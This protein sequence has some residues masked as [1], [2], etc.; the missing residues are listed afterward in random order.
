MKNKYVGISK[1][2]LNRR[3]MKKIIG[4]IWFFFIIVSVSADV[5]IDNNVLDYFFKGNEYYAKGNYEEAIKYL[6]KAIEIEKD[7]AEAYYKI[8]LALMDC[9]KEEEAILYLKKAIEIDPENGL[10]YYLMGYANMK[11]NEENAIQC[12]NVSIDIFKNALASDKK[13]KLNNFYKEEIAI[14]F[15]KMGSTYGIEKQLE[16]AEECYIKAIEYNNTDKKSYFYLG[17]IYFRNEKYNKAI[18]FLNI[19]IE[20]DRMYERAYYWKGISYGLMNKSK[21]AIECFKKA[22]EIDPDD[23]DAYNNMGFAYGILENYDEAIECYKKVVEIDPDHADSYFQMGIIY[24]R[25]ELSIT[26]FDYFY[27]AGLLYLKENDRDGVLKILEIMN[28]VDPDSPLIQKLKDKLY[29]E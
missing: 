23:A 1:R 19:A 12:F 14:S 16:K 13:N 3:K 2:K 22:V 27:Q 4:L 5:T 10:R 6:K 28:K 24:I 15:R 29:E 8:S 11:D 21:E 7:F 18:D 26:A 25:K 9:D 20:I 17:L